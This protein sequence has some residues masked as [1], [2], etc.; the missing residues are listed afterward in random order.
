[1]SDTK[2]TLRLYPKDGNYATYKYVPEIS[3]QINGLML[4][5]FLSPSMFR[6]GGIFWLR[7]KVWC[8]NY[9]RKKVFLRL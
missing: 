3:A 2:Q 7:G 8:R 9:R 4:K 5:Y 6:T 1:M